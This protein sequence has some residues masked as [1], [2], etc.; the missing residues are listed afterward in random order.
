MSAA[1]W[2]QLP[3]SKTLACKIIGNAVP[4]KMMSHL[5]SHLTSAN[6]VPRVDA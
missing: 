2:Y 3:K 4:P 1:D 6:V 5:M